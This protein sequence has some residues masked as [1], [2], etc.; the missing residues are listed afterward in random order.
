MKDPFTRQQ[1]KPEQ[2]IANR[3]K[4][5]EL[6]DYMDKKLKEMIGQ[7]K[8]SLLDTDTAVRIHTLIRVTLERSDITPCLNAQR[9]IIDILHGSSLS[10]LQQFIV[11]CQ[12]PQKALLIKL[13]QRRADPTL[14]A[15]LNISPSPAELVATAHLSCAQ[16]S[17]S[18]IKEVSRHSGKSA[19]KSLGL[20]VG[21]LDFSVTDA[22]L[23]SHFSAFEDS[24]VSVNVIRERGKSKFGFV[25]FSSSTDREKACRELQGS[26]LKGRAIKLS[27]KEK[28][29]SKKT[30]AEPPPPSSSEFEVTSEEASPLAATTVSD[31]SLTFGVKMSNIHSQTRDTELLQLSSAYG[32][33]LSVNFIAKEGYGYVNYATLGEAQAAAE[34]LNGCDLHGR[35]IRAKLQERKDG[36]QSDTRPAGLP[37]LRA[38]TL[39]HMAPKCTAE[40]STSPSKSDSTGGHSPTKTYGVK[41]TNLSSMTTK[42][43]LVTLACPH[44]R[45]ASI[46]VKTGYAYINFLDEED[47]GNAAS[48]L[49]GLQFAGS[50]IR[51]QVQGSQSRKVLAP[52]GPSLSSP[53]LIG[54]SMSSLTQLNTYPSAVASHMNM[55]PAVQSL[56]H[57]SVMPVPHQTFSHSPMA[58]PLTGPFASNPQ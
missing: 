3:D 28:S 17:Q 51:A 14:A 53:A 22:D 54:P 11:G 39:P 38:S 34:G 23:K 5:R 40:V 10:E 56:A 24:I 41:V 46:F 19:V 4:Q 9:Q 25:N 7:L 18:P 32:R 48:A 12:P 49:D 26:K 15:L 31:K 58:V 47:A 55:Y 13:T 8:P 33:P 1:L 35:M 37:A 20:W 16:T 27:I 57:G 42:E 44:G 30:L 43:H 21:L 50:A 36:K 29:T 2:V 45:V 52:I 6:E